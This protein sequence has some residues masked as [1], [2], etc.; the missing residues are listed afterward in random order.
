[1]HRTGHW[2]GLDV[3]MWECQHGDTAQLLQPGQVLTVEPGLYI[4]PDTK[5]L[6]TSQ[7]LTPP[8]GGWDSD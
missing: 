1:M 6:K 2:L 8:L 4:V 5:Q 3:M 7:R